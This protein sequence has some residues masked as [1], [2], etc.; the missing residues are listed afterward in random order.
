VHGLHLGWC[1]MLT[2]KIHAFQKDTNGQKSF[3]V[4]EK[5]S[6]FLNESQ[7]ARAINIQLKAGIEDISPTQINP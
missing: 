5:S 1:S 6:N 7:L 2:F 4:F 3:N